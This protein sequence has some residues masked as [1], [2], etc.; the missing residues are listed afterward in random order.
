MHIQAPFQITTEDIERSS[1]ES[2]DLGKWALIVTGC[3]QLFD[4]Q[5]DA[6]RCQRMLNTPNDPYEKSMQRSSD[7]L[8]QLLDA[9]Y[10]NLPRPEGT[11]STASCADCGQQAQ[12]DEI[13]TVCTNC[14]RGIIEEVRL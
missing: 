12:P 14:R 6:E 9:G 13:G 8:R 1:L 10:E 2:S 11:S 5:Q 4:T 7:N 3:Y